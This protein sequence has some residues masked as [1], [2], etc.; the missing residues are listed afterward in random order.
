MGNPGQCTERHDLL[1]LVPFTARVGWDEWDVKHQGPASGPRSWVQNQHLFRTRSCWYNSISLSLCRS[2][3]LSLILSPRCHLVACQQTN[4]L[5]D[6]ET[7]TS[8]GRK[9]DTQTWRCCV[10]RSW[11]NNGMSPERF[12]R[13]L[14]LKDLLVFYILLHVCYL[15]P[16]RLA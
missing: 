12:F 5:L 14:P 9:I 11:D 7:V 8:I 1:L 6:V 10:N 16:S 4:L 13:F 15:T 3:D 2:I